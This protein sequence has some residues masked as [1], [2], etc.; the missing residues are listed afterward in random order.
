M[1]A[2]TCE[3]AELTDGMD[4]L[5]LGCGWG[6]L[7]LW[8][9]EKY[10][11]SRIV[12]ISNSASQRQFIEARCRELEITNLQVLTRNVAEFETSSRFHRVV[13]VEMFE[14][15]RNHAVLLK[16]ISHWLKEDGKLFV[17]IFCH[18]DRPYAFEANSPS[19][20]MARHFF[21]GGIMPS[22]N[23]LREYS[24]NLTVTDQWQVN[25][26][27]YAR[28]NEAWLKRLDEHRE[29]LLE[30]FA[31]DSDRR[32]AKLRL[33]RWRMFFLSCAELFAYRNG[34]EWLVAHYLMEH[35]KVLAL[36]TS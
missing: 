29:E 32:T 33:Q 18:R 26:Q 19:D 1:L 16:R 21:T 5:E 14:H 35:A 10:P 28:T 24:D 23:L 3:R 30:L 22:A 15:V 2:L 8:M 17:H 13:S 20:W 31:K 11:N 6:S 34:E 12:A 27:H 25:G 4:I 36:T 7:S 9:A